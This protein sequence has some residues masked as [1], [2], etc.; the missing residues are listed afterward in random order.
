M[1]PLRA[2]ALQNGKIKFSG[3]FGVFFPGRLVARF[4]DE[5]G[6]SL[7]GVP[8]VDVTPTE[9]VVLEAEIAAQGKPA[10]LS[11]HLED[12]QGIDRGALQEVHVGAEENH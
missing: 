5:H 4:Y 6:R 2:T 10:R 8:V 11:L 1:R 9:P 7:G 12:E 3:S